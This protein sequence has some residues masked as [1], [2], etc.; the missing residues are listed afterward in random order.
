M[1][2]V[3]LLDLSDGLDLDMPGSTQLEF[4]VVIIFQEG[5]LVS[6]RG[7]LNKLVKD[8]RIGDHIRI[9]KSVVGVFFGYLNL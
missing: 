3:G 8:F 1:R 7:T 2:G 4:L 6:K 5:G 9:F